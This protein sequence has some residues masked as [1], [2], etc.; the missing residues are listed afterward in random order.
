MK[1]VS[2]TFFINRKVISSFFVLILG[3]ILTNVF[4]Q[5]QI[6]LSNKN[7]Q[8]SASL[9]EQSLLSSIT[10]YDYIPAVLIRD[11][12]IKELILLEGLA[13]EPVSTKLAFMT[14]QSGIDDLY[15]LD[16]D[17]TVIA[18]SNFQK[19]GSFYGKNYAFRPYFEL[20]KNTQQKQYY[21]AKGVTTGVRG[22]FISEPVIIQGQFLGVVVA[23]IVLDDWENKW[24]NSNQKI[25]VA[26]DQGVV[27]LSSKPEWLLSLIHI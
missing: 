2:N 16:A 3:L 8:H 25:I 12:S 5:W 6:N 19:E 13:H 23:K 24:R 15:V 17:G 1:E 11:E 9:F 20:A 26:D 18:T 4:Y 7:N 21:F 14:E 10:Q 22:F 27:I